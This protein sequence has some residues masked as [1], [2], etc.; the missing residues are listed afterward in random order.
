MS[1]PSLTGVAEDTGIQSGVGICLFKHKYGQN[2]MNRQN[3]SD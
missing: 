3:I 2:L 1:E